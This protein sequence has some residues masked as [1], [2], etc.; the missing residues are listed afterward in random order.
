MPPCL[1]RDG[2]T[3]GL[4][5]HDC[6]RLLEAPPNEDRHKQSWEQAD[7]HVLHFVHPWMTTLRMVGT[8]NIHSCMVSVGIVGVCCVCL[9]DRENT[10]SHGEEDCTELRR[11][12]QSSEHCTRS[13]PAIFECSCNLRAHTTQNPRDSSR[14]RQSREPKQTSRLDRYPG[15]DRIDDFPSTTL[16][17]DL[18]ILRRRT[19]PRPSRACQPAWTPGSKP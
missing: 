14:S 13:Q 11:L 1:P 17:G 18:L 6:R 10:K 2:K 9:T 19:F 7:I 8:R 12:H 3:V 16:I 5:P 15:L 4:S